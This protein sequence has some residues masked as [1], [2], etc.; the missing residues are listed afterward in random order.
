[1][2]LVYIR[3]FTMV[4]VIFDILVFVFYSKILKTYV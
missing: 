3:K 1:M 2:R 4:K